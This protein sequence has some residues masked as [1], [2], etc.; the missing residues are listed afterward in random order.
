[1]DGEHST[2]RRAA[3]SA[4]GSANRRAG[5]RLRRLLE[6]ERALW[7]SGFARI[8][9]AD[10]C[11]MGPLAGPV[12][13][14]AVI[15]P[16]GHGIRGVDDSKK[17]TPDTRERLAERIRREASCWAVSRVEI[18]EIDTLNIY[19]AGLVA[20]RRALDALAERPE[21]ALIDGRRLPDLRL[22]HEAIVGG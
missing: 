17:L 4:S 8:A 7:E 21:F 16:A 13:A 1:M 3:R 12:V 20:L 5:Q 10:E 18:R 19:H 9:G 15:F 22:A 6:R 14:A 11:G 2:G